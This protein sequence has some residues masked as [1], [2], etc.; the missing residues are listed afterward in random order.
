[1]AFKALRERRCTV[2]VRHRRDR[3]LWLV[4]RLLVWGHVSGVILYR[5]RRWRCRLRRL[6]ASGKE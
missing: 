2:G 6:L 4:L 3:L 5:F 1:M